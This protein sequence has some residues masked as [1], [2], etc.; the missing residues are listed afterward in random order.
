MSQAARLGVVDNELPPDVATSYVTNA[1]TAIPAANV[2]EILGGAGTTTSA[3]GNI[4]TVTVTGTGFTWNVV[5]SAMNPITLAPENG[6]IAKGAG[7]VHF[8]LP[9]AAAVGDTYWIKGYGN[10]WTLAQNAGQ[11]ITIGSQTSTVGVGGSLTATM[12]SDSMQILCMTAN[13]EFSEITVQGNPT[14]V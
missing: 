12:I 11:S 13:S 9:P 8:I 7:S 10:L 1:G 4:I 6:Y 14:I 2:L 5:T 3:A